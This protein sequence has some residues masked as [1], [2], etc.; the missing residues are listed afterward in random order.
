MEKYEDFKKKYDF[1]RYEQTNCVI[2][3]MYIRAENIYRKNLNINTDFSHFSDVPRIKD[4]YL[5]SS[6]SKIVTL[7]NIIY[8]I[9]PEL[10]IESI[11]WITQYH[12]HQQL[13]H[14]IENLSKIENKNELIDYFSN[15]AYEMNPY[16]KK[17]L[18]TSEF[19][20]MSMINELISY[21]DKIDIIES[22]IEIKVD[23]ECINFNLVKT[24]IDNK[25]FTISDES[26][27]IE[28]KTFVNE[29][30]KI[31]QESD[32]YKEIEEK[33]SFLKVSSTCINNIIRYLTDLQHELK[34]SLNDDIESLDI[35]T[36]GFHK[37]IQNHLND[38]SFPLKYLEIEYLNNENKVF[39]PY[40]LTNPI[41]GS[42]MRITK[43]YVQDLL[44]IYLTNFKITPNF[45]RPIYEL[46]TIS[47]LTTLNNINLF[48][49]IEELISYI[50]KLKNSYSENLK[51][52][53]NEK[54]K[55]IYNKK[56]TNV[57][58]YIIDLENILKILYI[59]DYELLPKQNRPSKN[60]IYKELD[61][62]R[63]T[64]Y[65]L[66]RIA[67]VYINEKKYIE[68]FAYTEKSS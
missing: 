21:R 2:Y 66:R 18:S 54:Y 40:F 4:I 20:G 14:I 23:K 37:I 31:L 68:L 7:Q 46:N 38:F 33:S 48:L 16:E 10:Y 24:K 3:E 28:Y 11:I 12:S 53:D 62:G 50:K 1:Q 60:T 36:S 17:L 65:L 32:I 56:T 59:Y 22:N 19:F 44:K 52:D 58:K 26:T 61:I 55:I 67:K 63:S 6:N 30:N 47:P 39:I 8:N 5:Y 13:I 51:I 27:Y 45:K 35:D 64:Y 29:I 42:Y 57:K 9:Y 25:I 15:L 49:P 41:D 43:K 34:V